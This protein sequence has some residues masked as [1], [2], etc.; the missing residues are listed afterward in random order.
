MTPDNPFS[1]I[2]YETSAEFLAR[3]AAERTGGQDAARLSVPAFI[4]REYVGRPSELET[5]WGFLRADRSYS[6]IFGPHAQDHDGAPATPLIE[7]ADT[8]ITGVGGLESEGSFVRLSGL[9]TGDDRVHL[10]ACGV[11]GDLGG[12]LVTD[13]GIAE[14]STAAGDPVGNLNALVVGAT[15][16]H[17]I[18]CAERRRRSGKGLGTVILTTGEAKA[19]VIVAAA[20]M[21]AVSELVTDALT[22]KAILRVLGR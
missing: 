8:L 16:H 5:V 7:Q 21:G 15:P 10:E 14:P 18:A 20:R 19:K 17:L 1:R 13:A 2:A 9:V 6:T 3:V 11:I 4:P 22:L 12:H